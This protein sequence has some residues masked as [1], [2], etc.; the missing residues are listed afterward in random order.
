MQLFHCFLYL[1]YEAIHHAHLNCQ[2]EDCAQI[3]VST[4]LIATILFSVATTIFKFPF[5]CNNLSGSP[6]L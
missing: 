1:M 3:L 6:S 4:H 2:S 5:L